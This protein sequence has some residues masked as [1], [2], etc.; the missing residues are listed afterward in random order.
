MPTEYERR[1]IDMRQGSYVMTLPKPWI[2]YYGLKPGDRLILTIN[3]DLTVRPLDKKKR[4]T[5]K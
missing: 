1:V 5:E 3:G 4:Q 2:R